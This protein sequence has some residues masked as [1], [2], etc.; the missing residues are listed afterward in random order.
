MLMQKLWDEVGESDEERDKA[1]LHIEQECLNVYKRKVD[2]AEKS[3]EH[4]LQTLEDAKL[5]LS[6]LLRSL[7]DKSFINIVSNGPHT[8]SIFNNNM[9]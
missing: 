4:L 9:K 5:E 8:T 1:L 6:T 2:Q 3:K 7:G